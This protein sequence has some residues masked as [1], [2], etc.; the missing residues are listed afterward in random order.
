MPQFIVS[1]EFHQEHATGVTVE[2]MAEDAVDA[3]NR[4]DEYFADDALSISE[5]TQVRSA[6]DADRGKYEVV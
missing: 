5:F 1:V 4:V 3:Q 6:T 2:V